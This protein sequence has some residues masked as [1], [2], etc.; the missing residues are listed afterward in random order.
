MAAPK[1]V[2]CLFFFLF[3][4]ANKKALINT[5]SQKNYKS[6]EP[7]IASWKSLCGF[8]FIY[9]CCC[10]CLGESAWIYI[11]MMARISLP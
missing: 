6:N 7:S 2:D 3:Q 5:F 8:T 1:T 11:F 4:N 9:H 10:C